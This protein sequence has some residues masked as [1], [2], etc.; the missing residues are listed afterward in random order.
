M[1]VANGSGPVEAYRL[2]GPH[3]ISQHMKATPQV[4]PFS[5]LEPR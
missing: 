1:D 3:S 2:T 4:Y 5:A